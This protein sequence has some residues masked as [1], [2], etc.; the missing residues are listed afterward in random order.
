MPQESK[1]ILFQVI[2]VTH[3]SRLLED[4]P[5]ILKK[6]QSLTGSMQEFLSIEVALPKLEKI[7]IVEFREAILS[8]VQIMEYQ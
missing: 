2:Q 5:P 8:R 6:I 3:P 7:L 1:V 4:P